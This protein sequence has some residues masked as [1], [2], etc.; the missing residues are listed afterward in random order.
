MIRAIF[1]IAMMLCSAAFVLAGSAAPAGAASPAAE[2]VKIKTICNNEMLESAAGSYVNAQRTGDISR[3][4]FAKKAKFRENM[5]EVQ[6]EKGLWNKALPIAFHRSYLDPAQ[7]KSFTE[8]IVTEGGHPYVIGTRLSVEFGEIVGV[9]SLVTDEGDWLFNADNYLKYSKMEN[10]DLLPPKKRSSRAYLI[11]AA[12]AYLD[13]FY[14]K[15]VVAPWGIP[16]ARLEGGLYTDDGMDPRPRCNVGIPEDPLMIVERSFVVDEELGVVNVFCRFGPG[17]QGMPDS[18]TFRIVDGK[19]RF[20][21]TLSINETAYEG[22]PPKKIEL[23][24]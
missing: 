20:I 15:S 24:Q 3:V 13:I 17:D 22:P 10:W 14:D 12:N 16:C 4:L 1:S 6:K 18:H 2:K 8:I 23:K 9:D 11:N 19:Y 5:K 7:C 21:H